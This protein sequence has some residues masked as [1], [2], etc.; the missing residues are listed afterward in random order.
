MKRF[1]H[2]QKTLQAP[3]SNWSVQGGLYTIENCLDNKLKDPGKM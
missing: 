1:R 3:I 2:I